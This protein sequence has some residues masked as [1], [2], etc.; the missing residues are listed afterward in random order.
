[1]IF[2]KTRPFFKD[3]IDFMISGEIVAQVLEAE[4]AFYIIERLWVNT[5]PEN[6][7]REH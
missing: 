7:D 3:L 2:I 4:D 6:A 5:N 1:M